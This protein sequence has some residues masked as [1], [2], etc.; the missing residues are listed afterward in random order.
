MWPVE[1]KRLD[2]IEKILLRVAELIKREISKVVLFLMQIN[3]Y[4]SISVDF[5]NFFYPTEK[6]F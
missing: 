4:I 1:A 3:I 5:L 2:L 6:K